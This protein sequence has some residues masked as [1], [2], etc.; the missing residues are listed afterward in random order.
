[1]SMA[2]VSEDFNEQYD[3]G[4]N[5]SPPRYTRTPSA[6]HREARLRIPETIDET[7]SAGR[8]HYNL[9][10][11]NKIL[12]MVSNPVQAKPRYMFH[13]KSV[14]VCISKSNGYI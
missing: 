13:S 14:I 7:H 1:M 10:L 12:S 11:G 9:D 6:T 8:K 5:G 3:D 4:F 2:S